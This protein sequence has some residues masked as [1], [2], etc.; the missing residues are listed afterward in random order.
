MVLSVSVLFFSLSPFLSLSALVKLSCPVAVPLWPPVCDWC[1]YWCP[2]DSGVMRLLQ[3]SQRSIMLPPRPLPTPTTAWQH[4]S[5]CVSQQHLE[6]MSVLVPLPCSGTKMTSLPE[7]SFKKKCAQEI[8]HPPVT[9]PP[10]SPPS[11]QFKFVP[12]HIQTLTWS[13]C[14]SSR[15]HAC[16]WTSSP[17]WSGGE[18]M[19]E[20]CRNMLQ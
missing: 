9:P 20:N 2:T 14:T 6:T 12:P 18:V 10:S 3:R 15:L 19:G 13:L 11:A 5:G 1:F 7:I 4:S 8:S 17:R 16:Q